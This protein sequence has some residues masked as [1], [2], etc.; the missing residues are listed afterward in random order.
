LCEKNDS[1]SKCGDEK[2]LSQFADSL[3]IY[4]AFAREYFQKIFFSDGSEMRERKR[5][6]NSFW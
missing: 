2:K 1:Q 4:D 3:S 6:E 5:E